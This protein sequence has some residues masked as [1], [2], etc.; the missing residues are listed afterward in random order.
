MKK[1]ILMI[2]CFIVFAFTGCSKDMNEKEVIKYLENRYHQKFT[3]VSTEKYPCEKHNHLNEQAETENKVDV[4]IYADE[5]GIEFHV[6][7][8]VRGMI[9]GTWCVADDYCVQELVSQ[10]ELYAPL[11]EFDFDFEYFDDISTYRERYAGFNVTVSDYEDIRPVA[12]LAFIVVQNDKAVLSDCGIIGDDF[13]VSIIPTIYLVDEDGA[14]LGKLKFRTEQIPQV[15]DKEA[16]IHIAEKRFSGWHNYDNDEKIPL[17]SGDKQ[18]EFIELN[19]YF[20]RTYNIQ[21]TVPLHEKMEFEQLRTL[22]ELTGYTF[23]PYKNKLCIEKDDDKITIKRTKG[24]SYD[25][26]IFSVYK[27]GGLFIPEGL[28]DNYLQE[29]LCSLTIADYYYLFG[30]KITVDYENGKAVVETD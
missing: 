2:L 9:M 23:K 21:D 25:N 12:E 1:F 6:Y 15:T 27:N 16:F 14:E 10:P 26:N 3:F 4:D 11:G 28:I 29:D 22:C 13:N 7:H 18:V 30:I 5:N 20:N 24:K 8:F 17:Y 19:N